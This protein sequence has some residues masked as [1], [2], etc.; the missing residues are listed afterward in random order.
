MPLKAI[1]YKKTDKWYV[2]WQR[3]TTSGTAS[4]NKW[5]R[6]ATND[7]EWYNEW[8]RMTQTV[9]TSDNERQRVVI[10]ANFK[11]FLKETY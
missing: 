11:L 6:V 4:D 7:N 5:I 3:E 1:V 2:E 10:S 9:T 8:Q